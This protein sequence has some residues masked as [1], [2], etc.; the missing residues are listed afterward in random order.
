MFGI[1]LLGIEGEEICVE[2][3]ADAFQLVGVYGAFWEDFVH[4]GP[5][6]GEL[7]GK[8]NYGFPLLV[9]SL[10]YKL[11]YVHS[12]QVS[13][14]APSPERINKKDVGVLFCLFYNSG[15]SIALGK[16]KQRQSAHAWVIYKHTTGE[17]GCVKLTFSYMHFPG[18]AN[19]SH[20]A[21]A[22]VAIIPFLLN[23]LDSNCRD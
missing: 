23:L 10:L 13:P 15:S 2:D 4:I 21:D 14:G 22:F 8:P 5:V 6:A 16:N 19:K 3:F 12:F 18:R 9:E 7:G 17:N 20:N 11:P 1:Y